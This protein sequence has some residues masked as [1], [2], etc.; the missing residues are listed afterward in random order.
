MYNKPFWYEPSTGDANSDTWQSRYGAGTF[1]IVL[2]GVHAHTPTAESDLQGVG[3][4]AVDTLTYRT[5]KIRYDAGQALNDVTVSTATL[6]GLT[7]AT[8]LTASMPVNDNQ[9]F[10]RN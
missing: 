7:S 5:Y 10:S 1:L 2:R 8:C 4:C 9:A 3:Q 6:G